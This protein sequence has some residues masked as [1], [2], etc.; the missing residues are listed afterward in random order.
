MR[1][2]TA[3]M[4]ALK[5]LRVLLSLLA[6]ICLWSTS[7]HA[8]VFA[9][10]FGDGVPSAYWQPVSGNAALT[11]VER[12]GRLEFTTTP[13]PALASKTFAGFLAKNWS[14]RTTS[15]F[16]AKVTVRNTAGGVTSATGSWQSLAFGF[17]KTGEPLTATGFPG[18]ARLWQ[19]GARRVNAT[20]TYRWVDYTKF[21]Q[22][23][24]TALAY[25]WYAN[26]DFPTEFYSTFNGAYAFDL[27][28]TTTVF[29]RYQTSN[30]TLY[31]STV[32]YNDPEAYYFAGFTGGQR[33]PVS[34]ALGG[35]AVFPAALSG[36]DSWIDTLRVDTG[37]VD[38]APGAVSASDGTF[39]GKVRVTWT[40][41]PNASG[42][43]VFR[44]ADGGELTQ[45]AQLGPTALAYDDTTAAPVT[46]YTYSVRTL[47][48][49]GD[50]FQ[51]SD[52]GWRNVAT[53]TG[54]AASDGTYT[55]KIRIT[56]SP[57]ESAV[58][59]SV[60]RAIGTDT[61]TLIGSTSGVDGTTYDD[62][63][64]AIAT[65]YI[66]SVKAITALGSTERSATDAGV[67]APAAPA[68]VAASDGTYGGK[69]RVS[70]TPLT[71]ATG[72]K[73]FRR[74][75]DGTAVLIATVVGGAVAFYDDFAAPATLV[76]Y[77]YS[78]KSTTV[79][80]DS[81]ASAE[82]S[83]WRTILAPTLTCSAGSS[84]TSVGITWA[85]ITSA[86]GYELYRAAPGGTATLLATLGTVNSYT[87]ET[88]EPLVNYAYTA[89]S[90]HALGAS[91]VGL[92]PA[93]GWRNVAGPS[94]IA[95]SDGLY[96]G[97]VNIAWSA[98]TG[99]TGYT[100]WRK[101]SSDAAAPTLLAT[102]QSAST[103]LYDDTT[104]VT[105]VSY[106]Y[107]AK[108]THALGS[109]PLGEGDN[110]WRNAAAPTSLVA[111]DGSFP[112]RI[113]LTWVQ[114][115]TAS[116]Y[117]VYRQLGD[118]PAEAIV[119]INGNSLVT[120]DDLTCARAT[121]YSYTVRSLTALGEGA[122][123][124]ADTGWRNVSAPTGVAA[125]D[126]TYT[127]KVR[128]TWTP[129]DGASGYKVYRQLGTALATQIGTISEGSATTWDDT[130]AAVATTY[131]YSLRAVCAL[132]ES[133]GVSNSDAG[134]RAPA[135]PTS[136]AASDGDFTG[137]IRVTW[138]PLDGATG[139]KIF[140][141]LEG[142]TAAQIGTVTGGTTAFYDDFTPERLQPYL[143]SVKV[144]TTVADSAA[145]GENAGWR[146]L[147][148]PVLACTAGTSIASVGVSWTALTGA[149]G[150][151][152]YRAAPGGASTLVATVGAVT[153]W[154]DET[155]EPLVNYAYTAK[156]LHA[157]GASP[158]GL[159]PASGWRN[160]AGPSSIAASDGLYPGRVNIAWS[161]VTGATGYTV[162]RKLSSDAAAPTLLATIQSASTLLYDDTTAVTGVSYRYQAKATHALGS[163]PL[164]EGDNGW[165][166][167]AAPTS[168]V[169]SDGSF[170][171]RIRLTWVQSPTASGYR[172]YRQLGDAPAEAIVTI[173][174]N[175]LVTYD[176]LT[177]ARATIYSYTVRSLTALGEGAPSNADTGWRN[178]SAPTGV[179]ASDGTYSDK[180]LVSWVA[181]DGATSYKVFRQI[182]TAAAT[183]IGTVSGDGIT[184]FEDT[185]NTALTVSSY[186]VQAVCAIGS[187]NA[188]AADSGWK[189]RP[190]PGS[191]V[192]T[193]GTYPT[194]V[195]V[196]WSAIYSATGY[197]VFRKIGDAATVQIGTTSSTTLLFDDSTIAV[198][199]VGLYTVKAVHALGTTAASAA[200][201]G[202]RT[203]TLA[204]SGAF[205]GEN[206]G[207]GGV[208][209]LPTNGDDSATNA[210]D[211]STGSGDANELGEDACTS[212][213]V[214]TDARDPEVGSEGDAGCARIIERISAQ[215]ATR[216]D[217]DETIALLADTTGSGIADGCAIYQG[218]VD[219]SGTVD[220]TDLVVFMDAWYRRNAF[221]GDVNRDGAINIIDFL[222]VSL[223]VEATTATG[224]ERAH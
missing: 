147:T 177:C 130:T 95:A 74:T 222:E 43:K 99:A 189:N 37:V 51:A 56:W 78:V 11:M 64:P 110:G 77:L 161:A 134:V 181:V 85:S 81:A 212:D 68:G 150:Y 9:D 92:T 162:W 217:G 58:G 59:Y 185:T 15:N 102:I 207:T 1:H 128:I 20:T 144:T 31:V 209:E 67:R 47:V 180:V 79:A 159:T 184:S 186:T 210:G 204:A 18:D 198:G 163:T 211:G 87:D 32:G 53:P 156:S 109:T 170:P 48:S 65:T 202:F 89:K 105:G 42:Y 187:G 154:T 194:K 206:D 221:H 116:G 196:T 165:R 219:L 8:Q 132:G 190:A 88:A 35:Y 140:R 55:D 148:A 4:R 208:A 176:D 178:V 14:I 139:Y 80:T 40:A 52:T 201:P 152:I 157:L 142:G 111:S 93:S 107:Q 200:D 158:V 86:T 199:Q 160:V 223:R 108:A 137:K 171:A 141:R 62:T 113:R 197:Q 96:P 60:W 169:A 138:T 146:N 63:T 220:A 45:V 54:V 2:Y 118:A 19:T 97:R 117:R 23:G 29:F 131:L 122:P 28:F 167:A 153:A 5:A 70:W 106:R 166:N 57:V 41:A 84:L 126:G 49:T 38:A 104:A 100:V 17:S 135:P 61:P 151:S 143:Y 182:G 39:G 82:D 13:A 72:Y 91:P 214:V 26:L 90:L 24:E 175:S 75:S 188:S 205:G 6:S 16:L 46:S 125:S 179:A 216:D 101:L 76:Q 103:L 203:P 173:N 12:N 224:V 34:L 112:A 193:D 123:S 133:A 36:A 119:T 27:E 124:N 168:L 71:G 120:Y 30:D 145:S 69:I 3:E 213:E 25:A 191:V 183:Q 21:G 155:A 136:V 98:V 7:A 164:G 83:G 174:G 127:D 73:V 195:R 149:T 172:V 129:S 44:Q 66:Y 121:I 22:F 115:P 33:H 218:D 10:D 94:S 114:S 50:G 215:S 192:A